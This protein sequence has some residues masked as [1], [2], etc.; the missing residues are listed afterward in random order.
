MSTRNDRFFR[1]MVSL[2]ELMDQF[3]DISKIRS[4]SDNYQAAER[5]YKALDTTPESIEREEEE[6]QNAYHRKIQAAKARLYRAGLKHLVPTLTL[7]I[8]NRYNREESLKS[9]PKRTYYRD[10]RALLEFFCGTTWC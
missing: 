4:F 2:E 5:M 7:I 9:M 3:D 10:R 6:Y 1:D 8:K